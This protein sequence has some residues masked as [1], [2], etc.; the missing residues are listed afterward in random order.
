MKTWNTISLSIAAI[1][2][3][4][5]CTKEDARPLRPVAEANGAAKQTR[6]VKFIDA[7]PVI[8]GGG[9]AEYA[10]S[11]DALPTAGTPFTLEPTVHQRPQVPPQ[12]SGPAVEVNGALGPDGV[13]QEPIKV[14]H[15]LEVE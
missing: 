14:E 8:D 13:V 12:D 10:G 3:F 5:S 11:D 9:P 2:L 4:A 6:E 15:L 1:T 7:M